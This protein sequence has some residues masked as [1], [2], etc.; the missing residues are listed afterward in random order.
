MGCGCGCERD[1]LMGALSLP[2]VKAGARFQFGYNTGYNTGPFQASDI[3]QGLNGMGLTSE[4]VSYVLSGTLSY[5]IAVEGK[6]GRDWASGS[7]FRDAIY[8]AIVGAGFSIDPATINFN[9]ETAPGAYTPPNVV[10][11]TPA[12]PGTPTPSGPSFLDELATSL[13]VTKNTAELIVFGGA[14]VLLLLVIKR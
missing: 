13:S 2:P 5:Y 9:V 1:S 4:A 12:G 7:D 14:A 8:N 11:T 10:S 3:A 6:S